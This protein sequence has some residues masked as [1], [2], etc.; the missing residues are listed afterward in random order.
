[1]RIF[2]CLVLSKY[3][4]EDEVTGRGPGPDSPGTYISLLRNADVFFGKIQIHQTL[5]FNP[6]HFMYPGWKI[7]TSQLEFSVTRPQLPRWPQTTDHPLWEVQ[8][9]VDFR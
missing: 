7:S 8:S 1:M 9:H 2:A 6:G 3:L 5:G 4:A